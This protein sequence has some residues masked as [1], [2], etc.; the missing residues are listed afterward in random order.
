[1]NFG[2]IK[3][4]VCLFQFQTAY[5]VVNYNSRGASDFRFTISVRATFEQ[6]LENYIVISF[7]SP[8]GVLLK[9]QK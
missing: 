9:I 8:V 6:R 1:M 2:D 3:S 7:R 4:K 5:P